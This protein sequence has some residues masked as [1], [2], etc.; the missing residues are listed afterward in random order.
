MCPIT[1]RLADPFWQQETRGKA[2]QEMAY[3]A[4]FV[5]NTENVRVYSFPVLRIY[6]Q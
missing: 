4:L 1:R 3:V 2:H 6:F 5:T